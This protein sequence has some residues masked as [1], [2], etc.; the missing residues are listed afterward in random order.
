[1]TEPLI[2]RRKHFHQRKLLFFRL[3]MNCPLRIMQYAD[4]TGH[5][6]FK[7]QSAEGKNP[8]GVYKIHFGKDAFKN[9]RFIREVDYDFY[10]P[11]ELS[12]FVDSYLLDH[13]PA[14]AGREFTPEDRVFQG[15]FIISKPKNVG[16]ATKRTIAQLTKICRRTSARILG[17]KYKTPGFNP[18]AVRHVVATATIKAS[19]SYEDAAL[20]LWDSPTTVRRA[21]AHVKRVEQLSRASREHWERIHARIEQARA[22]LA[23]KQA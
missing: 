3:I 16:N 21:Y 13:W 4:M 10:L 15:Q 1:M 7:L 22:A 23:P 19:G 20:L 11:A 8:A 12:P 14:I 17:H 9:R 18:Q 6:L 5:N 2:E